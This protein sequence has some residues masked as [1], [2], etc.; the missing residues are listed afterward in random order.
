MQ[1]FVTGF[2]FVSRWGRLALAIASFA[3]I[4][5]TAFVFTW[6]AVSPDVH[7]GSWSLAYQQWLGGN[8]F[9]I[10]TAIVALVAHAESFTAELGRRK[11]RH[12]F[13]AHIKE[14]R[15]DVSLPEFK[16]SHDAEIVLEAADLENARKRFTPQGV[17]DQY[18]AGDIRR[19][20]ASSDLE[21]ASYLID[22]IGKYTDSGPTLRTGQDLFDNGGSFLAFGLQTNPN[23]PYMIN[24]I[25]QYS[26]ISIKN[27]GVKVRNPEPAVEALSK[28]KDFRSIVM[29][30]SEGGYSADLRIETKTTDEI[31]ISQAESLAWNIGL[32]IIRRGA[33]GN[34]AE[35]RQIL[36]AGVGHGGT[37]GSAFW[38]AQ[39]WESLA[40]LLKAKSA[41]AVI[42]FTATPMHPDEGGGL[43]PEHRRPHVSQTIELCRGVLKS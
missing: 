28:I 8:I 10:F 14:K 17:P 43:H 34:D 39:H 27:T 35:C 20:I 16:I 6:N 42:V 24:S 5:V 25:N 2:L 13:G 26:S 37:S 31:V 32:V 11:F 23:T 21:G 15:Y 3:F 38:L 40:T 7:L 30:P 18:K 9:L 33:V 12:V 1:I 41:S 36:C 19:I 22:E 4:L 29:V